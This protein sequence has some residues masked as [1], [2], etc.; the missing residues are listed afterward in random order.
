M[1]TK[2]QN[3]YY[4]VCHLGKEETPNQPLVKKCTTRSAASLGKHSDGTH[5]QED[6][7]AGLSRVTPKKKKEKDKRQ[8]W[9]RE[10][11]K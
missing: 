7:P 5:T 8:K 1:K 2:I 10:D 11:Y 6:L 4:I 9:S 3:T